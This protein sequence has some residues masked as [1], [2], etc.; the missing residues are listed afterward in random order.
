M[1]LSST[2]PCKWHDLKIVIIH[3]QLDVMLLV[4]GGW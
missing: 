3:R 1:Q 4:V 2:V